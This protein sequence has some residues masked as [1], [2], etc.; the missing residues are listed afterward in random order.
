MKE[1]SMLVVAPKVQKALEHG[2]PVIALETTLI[3]HGIPKPRNLELAHALEEAVEQNG[4][5]AAT[6]G[7]LDGAVRIGMEERDLAAIARENNVQKC[8]T[9]DLA[10][11]IATG[12]LGA[13]TIASTIYLARRAGIRFIATGG[14]GGVHPGGQD[15][16]DISADLAE[17]ARSPVAIF[18]SGPKIILD[19]PRTMEV[20]ETHGVSVL[21]YQCVRM[22][23]FYVTE[24]D[25]EVPQAASTA[26]L[27]L[28]LR[29]Q[30]EIGWPGSIVVTNPPPKELA[31]QEAVISSLLAQ[32]Q[33]RASQQGLTGAKVTPFL[34]A[35]IA[36]SS[37][38]RSV[39]L[40]EALVISNAILAAQTARAYCAR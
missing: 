24:T 19:L 14:L 26:E 27:A 37:G 13:T 39:A 38:Q 25:I 34:L 16:L 36:A 11:V 2:L 18:C 7:V 40:N 17:L 3:A 8:S 6:I 15:S 35:E 33:Q 1:R 12:G 22:P 20:L 23:G 30:E 29:A 9:R 4:A 31:F 21:G 5:V 32:A 10:R 28:I